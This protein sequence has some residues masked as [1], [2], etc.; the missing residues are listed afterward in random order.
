MIVRGSRVFSNPV[1]NDEF[2]QHDGYEIFGE[3]VEMK[4]DERRITECYYNYCNRLYLRL[5]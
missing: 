1:T 4:S 3:T 5:K 2:D